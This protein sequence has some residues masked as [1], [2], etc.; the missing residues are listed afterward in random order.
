VRWKRLHAEL[1]EKYIDVP[2]VA[3]AVR[4]ADPDPATRPGERAP[5]FEVTTL[6]G[7]R[8]RLSDLHGRWVLLHFWATWCA[9]CREEMAWLHRAHARYVSLGLVIVSL[10]QDVTTR[11]VAAFRAGTWRMP[12]TNAWLA[13]PQRPWFERAYRTFAIPRLYLIE[14]GGRFAA[15]DD[16][17]RGE[18]LLEGLA[19]HLGSAA[20]GDGA[21]CEFAVSSPTP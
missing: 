2:G 13:E 5:D 3:R 1:R 10:S 4:E 14:P 18:R 19:R 11:D 7:G 12:W 8:L 9:P 21:T 6:D 17:L 20:S 16:T 15:G